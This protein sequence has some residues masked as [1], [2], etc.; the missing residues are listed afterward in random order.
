MEDH[1]RLQCSVKKWKALDRINIGEESNHCSIFW[2]FPDLRKP[3]LAWHL[4]L[5]M[6]KKRYI[7]DPRGGQ[8]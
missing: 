5:K 6:F 1:A 2:L 8:S 3:L 4:W 7:T